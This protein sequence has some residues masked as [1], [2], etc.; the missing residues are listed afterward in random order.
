MSTLQALRRLFASS[1]ALART[2]A[3]FAAVELAQARVQLLRWFGLAAAVLALATLAVIAASALAVLL[4]WDHLGWITLAAL[5]L[6]YAAAA[7]LAARRLMREVDGAPPLL[8]ETLAQIGQDCEALAA[9]RAAP[10]P[11]GAER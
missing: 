2:R 3:E 10:G 8:G 5:A 6:L 7:L 1:L 4:L 11:A 9:A